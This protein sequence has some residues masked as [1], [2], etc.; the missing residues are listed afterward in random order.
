MRATNTAITPIAVLAAEAINT[1]S[2]PTAHVSKGLSQ[3]AALMA[4]EG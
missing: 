1:S 3:K 2:A 4:L